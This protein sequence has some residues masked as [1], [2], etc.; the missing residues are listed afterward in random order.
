M[1]PT[2]GQG[3]AEKVL[4]NLVNN[5]DKTKFDVTVLTLFDIGVNKQFLNSDV[6]YCSCMKHSFRG[7]IHFFKLFSPK[8]LYKHFVANKGEFDILVSYLEGPTARIISGCVQDNKKLISW[9][10]SVQGTVQNASISFRSAKE[11]ASCY[12]KFDGI[13]CVAEIVKKNFLKLFPRTSLCEVLYN[14]L[15]SEK[16]A[17]LSNEEIHEMK[18]KNEFNL[19][20]VGTLKEVKGFDR[21]LRIIKH[22]L[23]EDYPVHLYILGRGPLQKQ[24]DDYIIDNHIEK[25]VTFLGYQTNPYKFV[26]KADLFVCSSYSEGFSTA[27]AEALI[28][29]IPVCTVSVSGMREM[30][31]NNEFGVIVENNDHALYLGIKHFLDDPELLN[32]YKKQ[33]IKRGEMF[34]TDQ[35]VSAVEDFLFKLYK[36]DSDD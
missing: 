30:L 20:A 10:H 24:F 12:E 28:L 9:I 1:M 33:A 16:I 34:K 7:N 15:E 4:V 18:I 32:Y 21:L 8:T 11:A 13:I 22:L 35:T 29:G 36:G 3:G 25:N 5:L 17:M 6:H 23:M 14:T 31:G 2:L 26:S 27:A 19:I